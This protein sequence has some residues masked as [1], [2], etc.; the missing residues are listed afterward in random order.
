MFTSFFQKAMLS[1]TFVP[2]IYGSRNAAGFV[3][4]AVLNNESLDCLWIGDSN[5]GYNGWG[6]CDGFQHGL[7]QAG[8]NMYGSMLWFPWNSQAAMGYRSQTF[9]SFSANTATGLVAGTG[10][11]SG[12]NA[13][14]KS[15]YSVGGGQLTIQGTAGTSPDFVDVPNAGRT[16][17]D[18]YSETSLWM[19][20]RNIQTGSE[21]AINECVPE[22]MP[23]GF[24][25]SLTFRAQVN[26]R[27]TGVQ[28]FT[29]RWANTSGSLNDGANTT[30]VSASTT[31]WTTYTHN[32]PAGS[33][34][35]YP[36]QSNSP[37]LVA[38]NVIKVAL[39]G[40]G[41][42]GIYAI[43]AGTSLGICSVY[44]PSTIG[45]SCSIMEY[46]GGAKLSDLASDISLAAT[47]F[48][49]MLLKETRERQIAAGGTGRVLICIQGGVN[50]GDTPAAAVAAVESMKTS[51]KAQWAALGYPAT[52][53]YFLFMVSHPVDAG[54]ATLTALRSYAKT[55]YTESADTLFVDL[56]EIA[57]YEKI[58]SN[59]WYAYDGNS[60]LDEATR[61]YEAIS[62]AIVMRLCRYAI[63]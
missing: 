4:D 41:V 18:S 45:S 22:P 3:L 28:K 58:L 30:A 19:Y 7:W 17:S 43:Q 20:M 12:A 16:S 46:R 55:Y 23:I 48:C 61:G 44:R 5:T 32:I 52:D 37:T 59:N 35:V 9:S 60:H 36:V 51:L 34:F 10:G 15:T 62:S 29:S 39:D 57:P 56:N 47:G 63:S 33:R 42:G 1:G 38:Q 6:W 54:D 53:L 14:L 11:S 21:S 26:L 27:N 24:N 25:D 40:S 31:A 49:N 13:G 50:S 8:S 2:G